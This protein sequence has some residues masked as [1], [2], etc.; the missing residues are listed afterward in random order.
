MTIYN[1]DNIRDIVP[2]TSGSSVIDNINAT[3][4]DIRTALNTLNARIN[5]TTTQSAVVKHGVP[6]GAGVFKGALVYFDTT[7]GAFL[8]AIALLSETPGPNGEFVEDPRARVE[9]MIIDMYE[10]GVTG[11]LLIEGMWEDTEC[12][13]NCLTHNNGNNIPVPTMAAGIYYVSP[14]TGGYAVDEPGDN[15]RQPVISHK[16]DGKFNLTVTLSNH[17]PFT[18]GVSAIR[19][20]LPVDG[21]LVSVENNRGI[22]YVDVHDPEVP[23]GDPS[24]SATAVAKIENGSQVLTNIISGILQGPGIAVDIGADGKATISLQ[25][26]LG[27]PIDATAYNHNGTSVTS[28]GQLTFVTFRQNAT[29][30]CIMSVP[31]MDSA[32]RKASPW[33]QVYGNTGDITTSTWFVPLDGSA[34]TIPTA[35]SMGGSVAYNEDASEHSFTGPGLLLCRMTATPT[36]TPLRLLRSGFVV[37][38]A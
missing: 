6:I 26:M 30:S 8:P 34:P 4:A 21:S 11:T 7:T 5:G 19:N 33:C 23:S 1:A 31:V 9:G 36:M 20:V 25:S 22:A 16:G 24:N 35:G 28:D 15:V 3:V 29:T 17:Y 18:Y 38:H 12:M 37:N 13:Q 14:F 27:A 10:G 2:G 32:P